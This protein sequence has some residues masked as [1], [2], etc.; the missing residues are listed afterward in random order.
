[1]AKILTLHQKPPE[2]PVDIYKQQVM[3]GVKV[4]DPY[5][6]LMIHYRKLKQYN[7]ELNVIKKAIATFRKMY[8][9]ITSRTL[10]SF[11]QRK[12]KSLSEEFNK[13]MGLLDKK[14]KEIYL[15]EPIPRWIKRQSIVEEK[16]KKQSH[17]GKLQPKKK[18]KK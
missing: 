16:I 7:D 3:E 5:D 12:I 11:N 10:K 1:M 13:K 2:D 15:P 18:K 17:T 6:R 8:A 9:E 14:G 4:A